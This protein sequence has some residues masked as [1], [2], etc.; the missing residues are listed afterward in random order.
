MCRLRLLKLLR[1]SL[2]SDRCVTL[3]HVMCICGVPHYV[4]PWFAG[5]ACLCRKCSVTLGIL[6]KVVLMVKGW[7]CTLCCAY[8]KRCRPRQEAMQLTANTDDMFKLSHHHPPIVA[9]HPRCIH[10]HPN[11]CTHILIHI[12]L[13]TLN[14]DMF[15]SLLP[16]V[17][18]TCH[19]PLLPATHCPC[20]LPPYAQAHPC[21]LSHPPVHIMA[22]CYHACLA[23][24][25]SECSNTAYVF[26]IYKC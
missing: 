10:T 1:A 2:L 5:C 4:V 9:Q 14:H 20:Q 16:L 23:N 13:H 17:V 6:I 8:A 11:T 19:L 12:W 24:I 25:P 22:R 18:V 26:Y 7:S 15:R 21:N 3:V